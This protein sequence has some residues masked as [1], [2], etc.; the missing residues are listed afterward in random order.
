MG[1][2]IEIIS[3]KRLIGKRVRMSLLNNK[4]FELWQSFMSERKAIRNNLTSDLYSIQVYDND[5][6]FK[7]FNQ[8]KEFEKWAAFEVEDFSKVP[9]NMEPFILK[10]GLY[11]VF[12]HKGASSTGPATF[13][14][15]F[16]T[17]LPISDYSV[18]TRPHFEILGQ[19]YK[20]DDPDSEEEIWI[21]IKLKE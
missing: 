15:I 7:N 21:P 2:K 5:F 16:G 13:R 6:D 14:Y 4:T 17:W 1:P 3:E 12:I 11:A 10:S 19:K 8:T 9:D 18:D 20:N